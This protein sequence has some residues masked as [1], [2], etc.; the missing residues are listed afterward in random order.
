MIKIAIIGDIHFNHKKPVSRIDDYVESVFEKLNKIR[1][2]LILE[3]IKDCFILGDVFHTPR[4]PIQFINR[5][6]SELSKFKQSGIN[7][8][9]IIGNHDLLNE[10][11]DW[12]EKTPIYTLFVSGVLQHVSSEKPLKIA[13]SGQNRNIKI[14]CFDYTELLKQP[15]REN[16]EICVCI[17]HRYYDFSFS[18][19][20]LT[21]K[22][23]DSLD[24][25]AYILGHD[26]ENYKTLKKNN[27]VLIRPGSLTRGTA[28]VHNISRKPCYSIVSFNVVNN[29][30]VINEEQREIDCPDGSL[31]FSEE[32]LQKKEKKDDIGVK[33]EN[34]LNTMR[35]NKTNKK[36]IYD[37]LD[38]MEM[39]KDTRRLIECY[40]TE[41]GFTREL[42]S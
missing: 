23:L 18:E 34:I 6:I 28:T 40:L 12:I 24:Y 16:N 35:E 25:D 15:Q 36:S 22:D 13:I 26:H 21:E 5:C 7:L 31:V 41:S 32:K 42:F 4:Q 3:N 29:K 33:F 17:A 8:Y 39:E 27:W 9:S 14:S 37:Y 38:S 10:R 20:S 2:D 11:L 19:L 1:S 30:V